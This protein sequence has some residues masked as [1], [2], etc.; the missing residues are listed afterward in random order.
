MFGLEK[1]ADDFDKIYES[2]QRDAT[3]ALLVRP[4]RWSGQT[5]GPDSYFGGFLGIFPAA[6]W[7]IYSFA[8]FSGKSLMD[9]L[10]LGEGVKSGTLSGVAQDGIRVLNLIPVVGMGAK[11]VGMALQEVGGASRFA[12]S[13][14]A[15]SAAG[16]EYA[17][18]CGATSNVVALRVS[19]QRVLMTLDKFG[20]AL[21]KVSPKAANFP[22]VW[23]REMLPALNRVGASANEINV[24]GGSLQTIEGIAA[25]G[26]GPV[27]F[28]VQW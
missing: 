7:S 15:T 28:G 3:D 22:G 23:F 17:M 18:S 21:G 14:W 16:G 13:A 27:V 11:G 26:K 5:F 2:S 9:L 1:I 10:R 4:G 19:G 20:A 25:Q 12:A 8:A 6:L 24:A